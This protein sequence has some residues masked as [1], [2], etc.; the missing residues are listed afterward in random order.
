MAKLAF[1]APRGSNIHYRAVC[2]RV[3]KICKQSRVSRTSSSPLFILARF[4]GDSRRFP[5][6]AIPRL[7]KGLLFVGPLYCGLS[8]CTLACMITKKRS[9][10][11]FPALAWEN[12]SN[13]SGTL[14]V[15]SHTPALA[16][17]IFVQDFVT[18]YAISYRS[19]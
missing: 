9:G 14:A 5:L 2:E 15:S 13:F 1:G 18:T 11:F 3:G 6:G 16:F 10:S 8:Y 17:H 7:C 12:V 4:V 19:N